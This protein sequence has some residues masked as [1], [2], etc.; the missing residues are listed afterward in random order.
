MSSKENPLTYELILKA[1]QFCLPFMLEKLEY[2]Q[3]INGLIVGFCYGTLFCVC[4]YELAIGNL[5]GNGLF[6]VF[7]G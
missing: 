2:I 6:N 1:L 4:P 3:L 7:W 5:R